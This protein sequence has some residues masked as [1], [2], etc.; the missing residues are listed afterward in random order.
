M[1]DNLE[2]FLMD[3]K[4]SEQNKMTFNSR[5]IVS[6]PVLNNPLR[7]AVF[8]LM[9]SRRGNETLS[10]APLVAMV[11]RDKKLFSMLL[12]AIVT[13]HL[14]KNSSTNAIIEFFNRN[15]NT[16]DIEKMEKIYSNSDEQFKLFMRNGR[17]MFSNVFN[18][19]VYNE[20][21]DVHYLPDDAKEMFLF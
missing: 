13:N 18:L 3:V 4:N 5:S 12:D 20:T 10:L 9:I 14:N 15:R 17:H 6:E 8:E 7:K 16:L 11:I 21:G 2:V 19:E 1:N